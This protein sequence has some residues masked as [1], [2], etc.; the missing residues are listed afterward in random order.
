[1]QKNLFVVSIILT[2]VALFKVIELYQYDIIVT[3]ANGGTLST[4]TY[5]FVYL[6]GAALIVQLI[7]AVLGLK[8]SRKTQ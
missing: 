5:T 7:I 8:Q 4:H 2:L 1:M 6:I 3:N